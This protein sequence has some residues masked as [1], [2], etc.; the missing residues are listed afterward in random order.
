MYLLLSILLLISTTHTTTNA[1]LVGDE[2][3]GKIEGGVFWVFTSS[4]VSIVNPNTCQVE[5]TFDQDANGQALPKEWNR[6][7]YMQV[8]RP[9]DQQQ[10]GD[11]PLTAEPEVLLQEKGA[12]ILI[13]SGETTPDTDGDDLPDEIGQVIVLDTTS[14]QK[15]PVLERVRVGGT[16]A[17]AYAV[18]NRNQVSTALQ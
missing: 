15:Y 16:P 17:N 7:V 11:I 12:Y 8:K 13:N 10:D 2:Q 9:Q 14:S 1:A 3:Y 18:H 4:G 5:H 6:G